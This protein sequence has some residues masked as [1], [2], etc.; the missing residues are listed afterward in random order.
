MHIAWE[1][2]P[3][4]YGGLGRHVHALARSQ[5][6]LGHEVTVITQQLDNHP[7]EYLDDGV[8]VIR[9]AP[10]PGLDFVPDNLLQW[11][12]ELDRSLAAAAIADIDTQA[13]DVVHAHDWMT[14]TAGGGAA[15]AAEAPLIATIH[16]TERGRHQGHLPGSI[17][18]SVDATEQQLCRMASAII[19]CSPA[20]REDIITQLGADPAKI[21][22]VPNG[23]EIAAWTATDQERAQAH[24]R[25]AGSGPLLVFTGRLEVEK[26]I[27]TLLDAM[28]TIRAELPRVR[29]VVVG[30]GGQERYF[31]HDIERHGL[32]ANVV[33]AGWLE[34]REL[35]GLIA[36]A[37]AAIVPSLY[38][39]FGMVALEAISLGAPLVV[40]ATGGLTS[41]V[42]DGKTG[43]TFSPG[44][45]QALAN[46]VLDTLADED[47]ARDRAHA[48]HATLG[49]RFDWR[50][51]AADTVAVYEQALGTDR[52][53]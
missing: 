29:L 39:P 50:T 47:A 5:A 51:I 43:I 7:H 13:P 36:A 28:T 9:R 44:D 19:A 23:I 42:T 6:A 32:Q 33:R 27:Y 11:V 49:E 40:A 10:T 26:G 25:W 14:T 18:E 31:D 52:V 41:I 1:Y 38:E 22:V 45:P 12:G 8:R 35:R 3:L 4:V 37:D 48:A 2:P 30:H 53:Q 46:A 17:S 24:E 34:E 21:T 20:M 15:A 16:A